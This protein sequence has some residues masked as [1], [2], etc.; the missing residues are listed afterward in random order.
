MRWELEP[1][2]TRG[3]VLGAYALFLLLALFLLGLIFLAYGVPP[4]K[5]YALLFSPLTDTLGLAEVAR[6]TI[7]LLLIGSGL[8]LAFRVGFFN[9]GAEGQLLLGAVGAAYVALFLPPGPWTL[10][11]MFLLGGSLGA[12]WVGIAAWLRVRFGANEILTTLM[13]NYLAYYLVVYLVA[14][15]WKGRQVFGFLYTDRFPPEAQLPRLGDTLVHWPTLVLGIAAALLLQALL[16][17]TPLGFEWRILGEN[18]KAARYLGLKQ[19]RL[20]LLAALSSGLLAGLSGV[21]E[22]AGIH[23]RLLEPAQISLGYG[24]T[25]ILVAWLARGR[26]LGVLLTAP[27]LGLVLAGGDA[28]KLALSMPFRVVDVVAGLL[29]LSFIGA[30]AL[31][32]HR[33]VW[34]R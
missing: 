7:P 30:E 16:F 6:R 4:L 10:P 24:F 11:L 2:P 5:A 25:A 21:G 26:P 8:A 18:P 1:N 12:V 29:L 31:S 3:K 34:R 14:G 33:L 13:Q 9:I 19:G 32:R 22:V 17:R 20:L 28:L 23:L 15:P 27:L